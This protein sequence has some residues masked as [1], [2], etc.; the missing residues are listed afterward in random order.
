MKSQTSKEYFLS[1][2]VIHAAML[3]GQV[4]FIGVAYLIN[5]SNEGGLAGENAADFTSSFQIIAVVLV[6]GGVIGSLSLSS[7]RLKSIRNK[8]GLRAKL[9]DYR[10]LLIMKYALLE[11][12][13]LTTIVFYLITGNLF[14]LMVVLPI[15]LLFF[16]G[17]PSKEKAIADLA[18]KNKERDSV[19]NPDAVVV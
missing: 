14:F 5:L 1:L 2:Q 17:R 19:E 10:S 6:L 4:I 8:V 15:L 9:L 16:M 7:S 13:C 11:A 18:L 12:P 3:I